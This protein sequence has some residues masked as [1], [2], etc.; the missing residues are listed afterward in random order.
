MKPLQ[1]ISAITAMIFTAGSMLTMW[2][3]A[4]AS[5]ANNTSEASYE[6]VKLW[7]LSFSLFSLAGIGVGIWLLVRKRHGWSVGASLLPAFV[8]FVTF[9]YLLNR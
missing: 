8:M 1:T 4:A 7:V 2:A 5:L 6:R 9:V 3:F